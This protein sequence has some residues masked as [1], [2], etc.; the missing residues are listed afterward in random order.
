MQIFNRSAL[1]GGGMALDGISAAQLADGDKAFVDSGGVHYAFLY[2]AASSAAESS[3]EVIAPDDAGGTG[4]W[5]MQS[6]KVATTDSPGVV[7]LATNA[8]VLAGTDATR[9]VT[10]A[11]NRYVLDGRVR[12]QN[13]LTNSGFGVW[14]RATAK[15]FGGPLSMVEGVTNGVCTTANTRDIVVGD[16]VHFITGDLV[17]QAFEV[18]AVTPNVSF[19]ID[20]NVSSGTCSAY[21]MVP[22]CAEANSNA[23]DGW[24][25]SNT[26]TVERTRKDVTGNALYGVIMTPLAAGEVLNTDVLPQHCRGQNVVLGA[27]VR[28]GVANHARLFVLDSAGMAYSPYHSGGGGWE[29]L[30]MTRPIAQTST[31]VCAGFFLSQ[32]SGTVSACCPML[33]LAS[34]LGAGRYQPVLDEIVWLAAPVTSDRLHGK[35][36]SPGNWAALNVEGDSHGRIP[37]NARALHIYTNCRDS[38]SSGTGNIA[39]ALRGANTA[40]SYVNCLAGRTNDAASL[41]CGW[42]S[43]DANGDIQHDSNASGTNTL[44]VVA[45]QYMAV[46]LG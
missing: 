33:A 24:A 30:E 36:F 27:W 16:L 40:S 25:K 19:T 8:E 45:F 42:A 5:L 17:G 37:A 15:T 43:C 44:D 1:T 46:Q 3:P 39:L 13:L 14:S 29:W 18:T 6:S 26:L 34:S 7:E 35:T 11:A 9:A 23:L 10:P 41:F 28:T 38:G 20:S 22:H 2:N 31:R 32:S 4:R 12:L 21:E